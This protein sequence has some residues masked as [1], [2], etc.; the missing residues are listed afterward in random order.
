MVFLGIRY[1]RR[2]SRVPTWFPVIFAVSMFAVGSLSGTADYG[3]AGRDGHGP[4]ATERIVRAGFRGDRG[5]RVPRRVVS[6]GRTPVAEHPR[7]SHRLCS[8]WL[9]GCRPRRS[10]RSVCRACSLPPGRS[11]S[12]HSQAHSPGPGRGPR[13]RALPACSLGLVAG[14]VAGGLLFLHA[15]SYAPVM[16]LAITIAVIPLGW[17]LDDQAILTDRSLR[18]RRGRRGVPRGRPRPAGD[19]GSRATR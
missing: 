1:R 4:R 8:H 2:G 15:R 7:C 6:N 12:S 17:R 16:P 5:S 13:F 3:S 9:W 14:A 10:D 19:P 11:P 18:R